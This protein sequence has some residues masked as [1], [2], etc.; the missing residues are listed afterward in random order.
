[1]TI[2]CAKWLVRND[3]TRIKTHGN[4]G[5]VVVATKDLD[6]VGAAVIREKPVLIFGS[7]SGGVHEAFK[8]ASEEA[9]EVVLDMFHPPLSNPS[10]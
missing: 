2:D 9:E 4:L 7:H 3:S 8:E 6:N 1:M 10:E 5:R